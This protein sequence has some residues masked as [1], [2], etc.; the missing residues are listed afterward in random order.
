M[1]GYHEAA[2]LPRGDI[3]SPCLQSKMGASFFH[4]VSSPGGT[5][6]TLHF[7]D[8]YL[9]SSEVMFDRGVSRT[10]DLNF[11]IYRAY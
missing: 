3:V 1:Y 7:H 8:A 6:C 5:T 2:K 4:F 11:H 9:Q 10:Y